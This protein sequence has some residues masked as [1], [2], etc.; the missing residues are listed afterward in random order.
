VKTPERSAVIAKAL[1]SESELP[2]D[3]AQHVAALAEARAAQRRATGNYLALSG[4]F[5]AML[6]VCIAGWYSFEP[7]ALA[8]GEWLDPLLRALAAQPWLVIGIAGFAVV[9]GLTFRRR[10]RT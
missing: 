7:G 2:V 8:L 6:A 1:T 3:F 10:A 4:A 5:V 9:Q